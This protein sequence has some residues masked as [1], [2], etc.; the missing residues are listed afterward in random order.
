[1]HHCK[2]TQCVIQAYRRIGVSVPCT[3]CL[4]HTP[5]KTRENSFAGM[6]TGSSMSTALFKYRTIEQMRSEH[7]RSEVVHTGVAKKPPIAIPFN[8]R[9]R[10]ICSSWEV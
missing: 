9:K 5:A 1:M 4:T 6:P 8:S 2:T 7:C 3:S 10:H